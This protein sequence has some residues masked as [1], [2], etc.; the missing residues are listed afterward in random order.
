MSTRV[1]RDGPET[2]LGKE[3]RCARP[4]SASLRA[5]VGEHDSASPLGI[6]HIH[7]ERQPVRKGHG[8]RFFSV[9]LLPKNLL[10]S[11]AAFLRLGS[12]QIR[13][14]IF[15]HHEVNDGSAD[16][17]SCDMF[18]QTVWFIGTN[19]HHGAATCGPGG[20]GCEVRSAA[21]TRN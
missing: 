11:C 13:D 7:H 6:V 18:D 16:R 1:D 15:C 2:S 3:F 4:A 14:A 12:S 8:F 21:P 5:T 10:K 20:T 17:W 9:I 19:D